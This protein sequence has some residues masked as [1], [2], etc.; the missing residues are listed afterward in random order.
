MQRAVGSHRK[1]WS[2]GEAGLICT[3]GQKGLS[4]LCS[5]L[6]F[7]PGTPPLLR[8]GAVCTAHVVMGV[9][10]WCMCA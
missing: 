4:T 10:D 2:H 7:S 1:R 3:H 6:I 9:I 8:T 5:R